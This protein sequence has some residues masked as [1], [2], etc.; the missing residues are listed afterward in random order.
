[1]GLVNAGVLTA[2]IE[3]DCRLLIACQ[4]QSVCQV[5]DG[6]RYFAG[7]K[8]PGEHGPPAFFAVLIA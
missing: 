6:A 4:S 2:A 8:A 5:R 3:T 7:I 1:M